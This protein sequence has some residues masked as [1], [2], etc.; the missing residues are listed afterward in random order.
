MT[1]DRGRRI[2]AFRWIVS[3]TV[4]IPIHD[5]EMGIQGSLGMVATAFLL[6]LEHDC[7]AAAKKIA[8]GDGRDLTRKSEMRMTLKRDWKRRRRTIATIYACIIYF[9]QTCPSDEMVAL[10]TLLMSLA[11]DESHSEL[12]ELVQPIVINA[13]QGDPDLWQLLEEEFDLLCRMIE[14]EDIN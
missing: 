11:V 10:L 8:D 1:T 2:E 9:D 13:A 6:G 12:S 4:F 3:R 5:S 14:A 7:Y